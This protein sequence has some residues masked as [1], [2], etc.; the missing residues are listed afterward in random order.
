MNGL[1]NKIS[2]FQ[3]YLLIDKKY[4]NNT[5]ASYKRDLVKFETYINKP[6]NDITELDIKTYLKR[7]HEELDERS[8]SRN[9]SAIRT[10][11]KFLMIEKYITINPMENIDMPKTGKYL[12][13][14]LTEQEIDSLLEIKLTDAFSF[15][16]KA[17][18]ELMYAT[19]LRVSELV[20]LH[21][22]DINLEM[23]VVRTMGKGSKERI[24]PIGDYSLKFLSIYLNEYRDKMIKKEYN[25]YLFLNNHGKQMTRQGFFKILKQLADEKNIQTH[26]S[27]HTLRHSFATHLLNHGADLRTIQE[28]LGH[29]DI[30]TT[31]IYT[32]VSNEQLRDNYDISHPHSKE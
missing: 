7:I 30:A 16:N 17:M 13:T 11:Y 20:N 14:V 32:H 24:I 4:S 22:H 9:V 19:G 29:S 3:Q 12:P 1:S 31:Q 28:L 26:F 27:P 25:D 21:I 8:I 6:I 10:F 15:R 2:D 5:I 23:A 18:L